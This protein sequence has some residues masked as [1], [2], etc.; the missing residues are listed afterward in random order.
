MYLMTNVLYRKQY[1]FKTKS[2]NFTREGGKNY[3]DFFKENPLQ[4]HPS[5]NTVGHK[6]LNETI[7]NEVSK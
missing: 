3:F 5:P 4:K 7:L 2:N 1:Y 6:P